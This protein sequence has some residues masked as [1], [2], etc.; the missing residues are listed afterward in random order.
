MSAAD[1]RGFDQSGEDCAEGSAHSGP[2][3]ARPPL[4]I[5]FHIPKNGGV[6][7][8]RMFKSKLGFW[9][10]SNLLHH[11]T[12][13]GFYSIHISERIPRIE[14]LSESAKKRVRFVEGH[15]GF[16]LHE[17]LPTPSAYITMLREP[18]DR[19]ASSYFYE[20]E[21]GH[22]SSDLSFEHWLQQ[23][24]PLRIWF[25]DN[26]QVRYL[27]GDEGK[28]VD[29]PHGECTEEMLEA[30]KKHLD[31]YFMLVGI[32]EQFDSS[33]ILL[34]RL[35]G[36]RHCY[37]GR[38]NVTKRRRRVDELPESTIALIH[39]YNA[40]DLELYRWALERF[41]KRI[42]DEGPSFQHELEQF[43]RRMDRLAGPMSR[44]Y[45][46]LGMGRPARRWLARKLV[47]R[48][49]KSG[50]SVESGKAEEHFKQDL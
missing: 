23:D 41:E 13:L 5:H 38:A 6:T 34:R 29:V 25:P 20:R 49:V 37:Y 10:P 2:G 19:T 32:L 40:L 39:K 14:S 35:M 3:K 16:G 33:V 8:S 22:I 17:V 46:I 15:A 28:I 50:P 1:A 47:R 12:V 26:A 11:S 48:H 31:E 30:A 42:A 36:W 9:P 21:Q 44:L 18:V 43:R 45:K 7:L 4:I 24:N 27:A